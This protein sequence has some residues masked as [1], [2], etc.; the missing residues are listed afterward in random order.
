VQDQRVFRGQEIE[1][2]DFVTSV[3][4]VTETTVTFVK[5]PDLDSEGTQEVSILVTDAGENVTKATAQLE[6]VVDNTAPTI[7][8]VQEL[9]TTVGGTISYKKGITVTDDMDDDVELSIDNSAVDL[10]T[11]GDYTV[12]YTA[13][14]HAGNQTTATTTVHV[15]TPTIE[16][17]TEDTINAAADAILASILTD[18]MSQYEQ[19]EAIYW[20]CHEKIAYVDGTP[21]TNYVQGAY[22]GLIY[23]KGDCYTYAMTAKC[24][25]TRAGITNMDIE[26]IP[27]G[28][29]MHYWNLIDIG[30]GWYHF[31]TCRRADGTTFFYKTD[32]EIKAYSDKH[33][34]THNYDR[35]KYPTI[36]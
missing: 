10:D 6:V 5:D 18:G 19:A 32:A 9:T 27:S 11:E 31:D 33:N 22:R 35:S 7:E 26:R 3:D 8:G 13:T 15:E 29:L 23:R 20:W 4:D 17:A 2:A 36:N 34:G 28:N 25:L 1:A 14:D 12:T 30:D 21:K 24:L 16:T